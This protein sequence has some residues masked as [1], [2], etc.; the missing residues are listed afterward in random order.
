MAEHRHSLAN[1]IQTAWFR[2][3]LAVFLWPLLPLSWLFGLI[4]LLRRRAYQNGW[5]RSERLAVPVVVVGNLIVG[6]AGKTPLALH[7]VEGLKAAGRRPGII[8]RGYGGRGEVSSVQA[9]SD[10]SLV[11]DE[12]VLLATRSQVPVYVGR[13][14]AEAGRALLAEHPE[15]DILVCDDGLQHYALARDVEI[16]VCDRRGAGNRTLLPA[17]PLREPES[18]LR[19]VDAVVVH[20]G[21]DCPGE[22]RFVMELV[23]APFY[24]LND[25]AERITAADL[26]GRSLHAI[27]G[28]GH[29]ARFFDTLRGLGLDFESHAFP[30]HHAYRA[31]EISFATDEVVL[32]T[33]KDAV[34]C[35]P[36]YRGEAWVLPVT[37]NVSPALPAFVLE[38]I[39]GRQVA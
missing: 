14:R 19:S 25:P 34:K 10:P 38:R 3:D 35:R 13:R 30:D 8:S 31:E 7:L 29:P 22:H 2:R 23:P 15:V 20:A 17:G 9:N 1:A 6:G 33:E 5:L 37:A 12:P 16:A 24:R 21:A 32:M 28:I 27:A 36:F 39:D 26:R 11:G 18:R 4:V